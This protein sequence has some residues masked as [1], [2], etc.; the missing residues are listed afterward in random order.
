MIKLFTEEIR[1]TEEFQMVSITGRVKQLVAGSG[2]KD[3]VVFIITPH[4]T[5]SIMIN[6]NLECV[7]KD[8]ERLLDRLV[9][10]DGDYVHTRMLHSYG[11]CSGNAPGHLRSMLCGNHMVLPV[12]NGKVVCGAAQ[13]IYFVEFD[14]LKVRKY[15]VQVMGEAAG[16]EKNG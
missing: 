12:Q 14:G 4:T 16:E 3:G 9:P 8:I 15:Y 11:T 13:D 1:S 7:E 2:V 5:T 6:E 10:V